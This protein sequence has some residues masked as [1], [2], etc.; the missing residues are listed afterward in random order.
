MK[1]LKINT[2]T[3]SPL[4]RSAERRRRLQAS[5]SQSGAGAADT[6]AIRAEVAAL[7]ALLSDMFTLEE[8]DGR[9]CLVSKYP[10]VSR[11]NITAYEP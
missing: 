2:L 9:V 11:D 1:N 7:S 5:S 4:P 10:I 6:A 8:I 3:R